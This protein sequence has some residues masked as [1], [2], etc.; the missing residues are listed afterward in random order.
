LNIHVGVDEIIKFRPMSADD[1]SAEDRREDKSRDIPN[2]SALGAG[3]TRGVYTKGIAT[4]AILG[5]GP[6]EERT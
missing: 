6:S 5:I 1:F 2:N 4:R 3:A